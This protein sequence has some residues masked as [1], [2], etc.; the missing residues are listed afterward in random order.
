MV[1]CHSSPV[2]RS[3][4]WEAI[5]LPGNQKM[6]CLNGRKTL[7][8]HLPRRFTELPLPKNGGIVYKEAG[9]TKVAKEAL[10]VRR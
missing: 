9:T 10:S 7:S 8:V 2:S 5:F 3:L 4:P 1:F 6:L